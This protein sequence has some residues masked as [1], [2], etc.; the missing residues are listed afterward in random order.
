MENMNQALDNASP[1]ITFRIENATIIAYTKDKELLVT[2]CGAEPI[3]KLVA[4]WQ[5]FLVTGLAGDCRNIIRYAK[6]IAVNHTFE[7]DS[8]PSSIYLAKKTG[9]ILQQQSLAPGRRPYC[10][11]CLIIDSASYLN[12]NN[13]NT[14]IGRCIHKIDYN[15]EVS[16]LTAACIGMNASKGEKMLYK[17]MIE[18]P[19]LFK[20][21]N[22]EIIKNM[23][24][25]VMETMLGNNEEVL[26]TKEIKVVIIPDIIL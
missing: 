17:R 11:Q 1:I 7:Y 6:H 19:E 4:P 15:G 5:S 22:I 18:D 8:P 20:Y 3:N 16:Q 24:I 13:I 9:D 14:N 21:K 25:R 10:C 23:T 2:S 12:H 26:N